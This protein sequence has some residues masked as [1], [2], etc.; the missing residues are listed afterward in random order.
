MAIIPVNHTYGMNAFID[1]NPPKSVYRKSLRIKQAMEMSIVLQ[2]AA[3]P[4]SGV[5]KQTGGTTEW[6]V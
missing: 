5:G 3:E 6:T 2:S 4:M 1:Y